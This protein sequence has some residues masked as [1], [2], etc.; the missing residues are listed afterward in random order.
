[1]KTSEASRAHILTSVCTVPCAK[2]GSSGFCCIW[3]PTI[4]LK[5]ANILLQVLIL[6]PHCRIC[7]A[8]YEVFWFYRGVASES[9][10]SFTQKAPIP[11]LRN[12]IMVFIDIFPEIR[13]AKGLIWAHCLFYKLLFLFLPCL[14]KWKAE[15]YLLSDKN[16]MP[17]YQSI[18]QCLA[19]HQFYVCN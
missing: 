4:T 14:R 9:P 13:E 17:V 8:S 5:C 15:P 3:R 19:G 11:S 12:E 7:V 10:N 16:F 1:M 2:P 18:C 6:S